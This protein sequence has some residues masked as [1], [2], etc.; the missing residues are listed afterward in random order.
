I[1]STDENLTHVEGFMRY[2]R[3]GI[4]ETEQSQ[5]ARHFADFGLKLR[6]KDQN[7]WYLLESFYTLDN[8]NYETFSI[9]AQHNWLSDSSHWF[10]EARINN[11]W[12]NDSQ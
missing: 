8:Q 1:I 11:R 3:A 12:Q 6:N 5:S 4:F 10:S 9:N 2:N 7:H